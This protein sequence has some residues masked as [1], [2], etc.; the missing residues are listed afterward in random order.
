MNLHQP[1]EH[2]SGGDEHDLLT[3]MVEEAIAETVVTRPA[4]TASLAEQP[5][6]IE[7]I[8]AE[9]FLADAVTF[10][11]TRPDAGDLLRRLH[12]LIDAPPG[13]V[14]EAPAADREAASEV[15]SSSS[16]PKAH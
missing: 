11:R 4:R 2:G 13:E 16:S 6:T 10:L 1:Y 3:A 8:S 14:S 12:A 9:G 7:P 15:V 5:D